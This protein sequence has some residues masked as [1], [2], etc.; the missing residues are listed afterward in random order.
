MVYSCAGSISSFS[1]TRKRTRTARRLF[2][3]AIEARS[4][5][6]PRLQRDV[7]DAQSRLALFLVGRARSIARSGHL[8]R[9]R[10]IDFDR[11]GA[12]FAELGNAKLHKNS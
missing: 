3:E 2:E 5:I 6:Q 1:S 8:S 12:R 4:A 9:R 11:L 7:A 10:A